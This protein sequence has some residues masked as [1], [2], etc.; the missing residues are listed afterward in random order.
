MGDRAEVSDV[1]DAMLLVTY[2]IYL[3][4]IYFFGSVLVFVL[5]GTKV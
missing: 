2:L 5:Y 1:I 4:D 3:I